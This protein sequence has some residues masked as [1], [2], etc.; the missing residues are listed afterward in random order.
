MAERTQSEI[1]LVAKIASTLA[2][3]WGD[4]GVSIAHT[5]E[6]ARMMGWNPHDF[7]VVK[8]IEASMRSR[9]RIVRI[10]ADDTDIPF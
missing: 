2:E 8:P 3:Y 1:R 7:I 9:L 10:D 4:G 6:A 5:A